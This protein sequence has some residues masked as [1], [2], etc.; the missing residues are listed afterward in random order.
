MWYKFE[1]LY[2]PRVVIPSETSSQWTLK[3]SRDA[4]VAYDHGTAI[5]EFLIA[6]ATIFLFTMVVTP[7][8]L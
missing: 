3:T 7:V 5:S 6:Q 8:L 1:T 4:A 2:L